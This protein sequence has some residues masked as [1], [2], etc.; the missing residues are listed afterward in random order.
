[1]NDPARIQETKRELISLGVE[2]CLSAYVDIHGVLK[3]KTVP[4]EKFEKMAM[5]SELFTAGALDGMGLIGPEQDE[6]AAVPDLDTMIVLPWD[7]KVAWFAADLFYHDKP[8]VNCS[9]TILRNAVE[10][11]RSLG[12][13]MNLGVETEFY[14]Y[15][16]TDTGLE[17]LQPTRF[18]GPC[19]AYDV[20]QTLQA[21]PF[22]DALVTAM[23]GLG[24]GVYS[25][26]AEGGHG[27]FETDFNYA[28]VLTMADRVTFFRLMAKSIARQH[29]LVATFMP[30]PFAKDF[31]S[32]AHFN[33]SLA[34]VA[35]GKNLFDKEHNP[36]G[37]LAE[38]HGIAFPDIGYHFVAGLLK[39]AEAITAVACP[40][41]NSYK[42][43]IAQG[44]MPDMSWAPVLRCYG[45]NNRSA[46]LRLPM[47][48]PCIENRA[49]DMAANFYLASA[50]SLRAGLEGVEEASDPGRPF[51]QNLYQ[52][53]SKPSASGV[54][55]LPGGSIHRLPRTLLEAL[56]GFEVDELVPD[57]FGQE[58]RDIFLDF[59]LKEW[60]RDFYQVGQEERDQMLTFL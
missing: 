21:L 53:L 30:K 48:R 57:V 32:G 12:Y 8:Y 15:R 54:H 39:H 33:M 36:P 42:G 37:S 20:D 16:P 14:V 4:V 1:M 11:A 56:Q 35:T 52:S 60:E 19:P 7:K 44:D 55:T 34:D 28:D 58:F 17:Q 43:L 25:F 49:P 13:S 29:G 38:Q 6:C 3:S 26:D 31:R 47:S 40:T 9:R 41:Y 46:M 23:N 45:D 22:L 24:W 2:Y 51:N 59:K 5:G 18:Q 27:Q 50:L 10:H